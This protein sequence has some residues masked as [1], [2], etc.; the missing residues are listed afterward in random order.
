VGLS[1]PKQEKFMAEFLPR[2]DVT[3]MI[4]VGAAFDFHSGASTG[5]ALDAAQRAGMVLSF[6]PGTPA[7][8]KTIFAEQSAV[9]AGSHR[10]A[11]WIE[12]LFTGMR[13]GRIC[14]SRT[15]VWGIS[16]PVKRPNERKSD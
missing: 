6:V 2:L 11:L 15:A 1:T 14:L 7:A 5:A 16:I 10:A 3:L 8:G 4:G 9:R 13:P 12:T